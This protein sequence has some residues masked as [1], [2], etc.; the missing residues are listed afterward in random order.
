MG[1]FGPDFWFQSHAGSI[2]ARSGNASGYT[3]SGFQSHAGSIEAPSWAQTSP[4]GPRFQ[5]H[6]GSI[7]AEDVN[8]KH[9]IVILFQSHAGSIEARASFHS[10]RAVEMSFNPTLVRLRRCSS[11]GCLHHLHRFNPTLV[12]LRPGRGHRR[13]L[14]SLLFQSHAGSIEA[15]DEGQSVLGQAPFQS[16]AG[17]IEASE[18]L[19]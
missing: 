4:R 1:C 5:S 16:H 7:E 12:R 11:P 3:A 14:R 13:G 17:S 10:P 19:G 6:A 2:E 18:A 15:K 8:S 9:R